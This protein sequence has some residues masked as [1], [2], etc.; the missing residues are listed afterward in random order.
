LKS[1]YSWWRGA[2][3]WWTLELNRSFYWFDRGLRSFSY[4]DDFIDCT[5]LRFG[6]C[7]PTLIA[8]T[9]TQ[10]LSLRSTSSIYLTPSYVLSNLIEFL[11]ELQTDTVIVLQHNLI[12]LHTLRKRIEAAFLGCYR[13]L[14]RCQWVFWRFWWLFWRYQWV[15][16]GWLRQRRHLVGCINGVVFLIRL[17]LGYEVLVLFLLIVVC[18]ISFDVIVQL[19]Q[20]QIELHVLKTFNFC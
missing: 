17:L 7:Q 11:L 2:Y 12:Y 14:W 1:R 18:Y 19:P 13:I 5:F 8:V 16:R 6:R 9:L 15:F 20:N 10:Y 3:L 4:L